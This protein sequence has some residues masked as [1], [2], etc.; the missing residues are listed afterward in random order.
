MRSPSALGQRWRAH[1]YCKYHVR[2]RERDT[3]YTYQTS[4]SGSYG[5]PITILN[6]SSE[7]SSLETSAPWNRKL[8]CSIISCRVSCWSTSRKEGRANSCSTPYPRI[9]RLRM[10]SICVIQPVESCFSSRGV[11]YLFSLAIRTC[12]SPRLLY[13]RPTSA[14]KFCIVPGAW[15]GSSSQRRYTR[16][17]VLAVVVTLG[18]PWMDGI[19]CER[20]ETWSCW[21]TLSFCRGLD[22]CSSNCESSGQSGGQSRFW[23]CD[24]NSCLSV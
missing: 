23:K 24:V 4:T 2:Q 5:N 20:F 13:L 6:T 12:K 17:C 10:V 11:S 14:P 8:I 16:P 7:V 18:G 1:L 3:I 9:L 15:I 21:S 22:F 19:S